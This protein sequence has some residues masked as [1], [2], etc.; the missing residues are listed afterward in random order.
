MPC[1]AAAL[2]SAGARFSTFSQC[3]LGSR[4]QKW[5]TIASVGELAGTPSHQN[6]FSLWDRIGSVEYDQD[7]EPP[8]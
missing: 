2:G 6:L 7:S 1:I 5:T 8:A 4:A 3:K